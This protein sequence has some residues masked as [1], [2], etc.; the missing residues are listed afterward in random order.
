MFLSLVQAVPRRRVRIVHGVTT[1]ANHAI[2]DQYQS[3]RMNLR[4]I[5]IIQVIIDSPLCVLE[6]NMCLPI[7]LH[8]G[9][10]VSIWSRLPKYMRRRLTRDGGCRAG[11][12]LSFQ[13]RLFPSITEAVRD[14]SVC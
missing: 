6:E 12:S 2:T 3:E 8:F 13:I 14:G 5:I 10:R 9:G 11:S 4:T 7:Q 1:L